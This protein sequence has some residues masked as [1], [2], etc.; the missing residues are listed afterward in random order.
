MTVSV[1]CDGRRRIV[2]WSLTKGDIGKGGRGDGRFF[3][4][5][6]DFGEELGVGDGQIFDFLF[7]LFD[8][9]FEDFVLFAG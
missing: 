3:A 9:S 8:F 6:F 2:I 1:L 5:D 7:E 4:V